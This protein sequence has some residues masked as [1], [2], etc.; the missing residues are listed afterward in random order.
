[1]FGR[2]A[3]ILPEKIGKGPSEVEAEAHKNLMFVFK[4]KVFMW[5]FSASLRK[6]GDSEPKIFTRRPLKIPIKPEIS[7]NLKTFFEPQMRERSLGMYSFLNI[8]SRTSF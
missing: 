1:M 5:S 6:N 7:S 8:L 2:R 3:L 4:E